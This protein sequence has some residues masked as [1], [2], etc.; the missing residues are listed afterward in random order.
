M[1][2]GKMRLCR[3]LQVG[4]LISLDYLWTTNM[5]LRYLDESSPDY[6]AAMSACH[7]RAADRMVNGAVSNGGI[8]IKLGQGLCS[9]NHLFP[10]EYIRTLQ[11]LEDRALVRGYKEVSE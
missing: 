4:F 3:S 6:V 2:E 11:V 7:Q 1:V 10:V 8:Y 9:F 5:T